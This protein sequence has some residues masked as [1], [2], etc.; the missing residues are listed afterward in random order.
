MVTFR[1]ILVSVYYTIGEVDDSGY[2]LTCQNLLHTTKARVFSNVSLA[3]L[4]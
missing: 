1:K 2:Q 4:V 3:Y